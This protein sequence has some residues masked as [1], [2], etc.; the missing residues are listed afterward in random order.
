[1]LI[2]SDDSILWNTDAYRYDTIHH[3][4]VANT[5]I[6]SQAQNIAQTSLPDELWGV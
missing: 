1:M 6:T 2:T 3:D 4:M 5:V